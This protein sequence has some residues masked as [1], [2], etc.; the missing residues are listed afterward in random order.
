[1]LFQTSSGQ[2]DASSVSVRKSVPLTL[3]RHPATELQFEV[4]GGPFFKSFEFDLHPEL[5]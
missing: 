2:R 4:A 1:M 5:L 3:E